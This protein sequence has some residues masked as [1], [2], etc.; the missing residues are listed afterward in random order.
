MP[1][2]E[3]P[4]APAPIIDAPIADAVAPDS[5]EGEQPAPDAGNGEQELSLLEVMA[6]PDRY[7][8]A[9]E[10]GIT[11]EDFQQAIRE[12]SS[13]DEAEKV[14]AAAQ[15]LREQE[16]EAEE[17]I[18]NREEAF[19][20][21]DFKGR[22][23]ASKI[24]SR[25]EQ[26]HRD[27]DE[28]ALIERT[29]DGRLQLIDEIN[30]VYLGGVA[31]TALTTQRTVDAILADHADALTKADQE[32]LR[33]ARYEYARKGNPDAYLRLAFKAVAEHA[34]AQ[35]EAKGQAKGE[36]QAE[37]TKE[38][39]TVMAKLRDAG[40]LTA[41]AVNGKRA[42]NAGDRKQELVREME[43]I[44]VTTPE[45]LQKWREQERDMQK[46]LSGR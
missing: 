23:S 6:D 28:S 17:G 41:P 8:A 25:I 4:E 36:K 42:H 45:G 3:T 13:G 14:R 18:R 7:K 43:S 34:A 24:T 38:S 20:S 26:Y 27:G 39:L 32:A 10:A 44:D 29:T 22:Q 1:D 2:V 35:A 15:K 31:S 30:D 5:P 46:R 33:Q 37:A 11:P 19:T 9:I 16:R 40:L 21:Y 12:S